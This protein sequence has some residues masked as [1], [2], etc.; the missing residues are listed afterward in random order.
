MQEKKFSIEEALRFGWENTKSHFGFFA[1]LLVVVFI[2]SAMF[3]VIENITMREMQLVSLAARLVSAV[4]SLILGMGLVRI[5]LKFVDGQP[6]EF[7]DLFSGMQNFISYA[8]ASIL[9]GLM[10]FCGFIL[11]IIPGII[12]LIQF[13]FATYSIVD[14]Q[15]RPIEALKRSA[16]LTKGT[17]LNLLLFGLVILLLNFAGLLAFIIGLFVSIPVSML[18]TA[19]VYRQLSQQA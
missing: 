16:Q 8:A 19:Y 4:V 6:A 13:Q 10:V 12:L 11:L 15:T 14:E 18:A 2:I 1:I 9:Y 5:S 17:K 3:S 7:S